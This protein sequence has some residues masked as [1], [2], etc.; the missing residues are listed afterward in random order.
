MR[1]ETN[2]CA[3]E[4]FQGLAKFPQISARMLPTGSHYEKARPPS[5]LADFARGSSLWVSRRTGVRQGKATA[6]TV[7]RALTLR[8]WTPTQTCV[9][10]RPVRP[11]ALP[12]LP[13]LALLTRNRHTKARLIRLRPA[14]DIQVSYGPNTDVGGPGPPRPNDFSSWCLTMVE[15][16]CSFSMFYGRPST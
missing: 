4:V 5:R 2:P 16:K 3:S 10:R 6:L 1:R 8:N 11:T 15:A 13:G 14:K 12:R 7:N 9:R